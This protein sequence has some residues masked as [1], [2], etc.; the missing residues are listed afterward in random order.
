MNAKKTTLAICLTTCLT[1]LSLAD[2]PS[3]PADPQ[4]SAQSPELSQ[5]TPDTNQ[6]SGAV[7][8]LKDAATT[9]NTPTTEENQAR[10][11]EVPDQNVATQKTDASNETPTTNN[12]NEQ[13][14]E[15]LGKE[16]LE[17]NKQDPDVQTTSTGLQYKV[18]EEGNGPK[19][20]LDDQVTVR[21][22]GKLPDGKVFDSSYQRNQDAT[23]GLKQVITGWQEA[24]QMMPEGSTWEIT[25]PADLAYGT[26]GVPGVI[27]PN[28]V[29][30][31]KVNLVKIVPAN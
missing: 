20:N 13:K 11:N 10:V 28:S 22:E 24:L 30:T 27:P 21:Y 3:Q 5:Q 19:P 2:T 12:E 16:L 26:Q 8:K 17:K 31:F 7:N 4:N 18:L 6:S 25:I 23:F 29:L 14:M 9:S 15:T 1:G